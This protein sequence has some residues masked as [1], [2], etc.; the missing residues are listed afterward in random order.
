MF[1]DG[2]QPWSKI[3]HTCSSALITD[4]TGWDGKT[5]SRRARGDDLL[6]PSGLEWLNRSIKYT[7]FCQLERR[8]WLVG[9]RFF[10]GSVCLFVWMLFAFSG[11]AYYGCCGLNGSENGWCVWQT[12]KYPSSAYQESPCVLRQEER[13]SNCYSPLNSAQLVCDS[14]IVVLTKWQ[15]VA[16]LFSERSVFFNE[17]CLNNSL[18]F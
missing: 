12:Q 6:L 7:C 15:T 2:N 18:I 1:A 4:V 16:M 3:I 10:K 14:D 17:Y 5:C 9:P 13:Q 8:F 11:V